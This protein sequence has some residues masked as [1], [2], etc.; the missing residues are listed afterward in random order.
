[1]PGGD[2]MPRPQK[3]FTVKKRNDSKTFQ[4]TINPASGL[5]G[6]V[7]RDWQRCSF[8]DLPD[9]LALYR[10]PKNKP[11]AETGVMAL[12]R[13]LEKRLEQ[14]EARK[15]FNE[16]VTVGEWVKRF[17]EIETSPRTGRNANKNKPYSLGTLDT[18]KTYY[19]CH[20]KDDP[21]SEILMSEV[22]EDD[23]T[24][25]T[26]RLSVKKLRNGNPC[27]GSRTFAGVIIF[28]RMCFTEYRKKHKR[29]FNPFQDLDAPQI[30][31]VSRDALPE[32]E[33]L[34][35]FAPGVL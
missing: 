12:I 18:Y 24:I 15:S 5:P 20:I 28:L 1:M 32:D 35:L 30:N 26:N 31:S 25:Y 9:A 27:G 2:V 19:N 8:Q 13:Y 34:K 23:V 29:W 7:C 6:K 4:F 10:A 16:A 22:D 14:N 3:P 21:F 17:T 11:A 33:F